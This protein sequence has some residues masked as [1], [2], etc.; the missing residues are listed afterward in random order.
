MNILA[1]NVRTFGKPKIIRYV[2]KNAFSPKPKVDSAI[3]AI[4]IYKK[5]A[6][7]CDLKTYFSLISRAFLHKRKTLRNSLKDSGAVEFLEKA[8][9]D[10]S[11]R[12]ETVSIEEWETL[13]KLFSAFFDHR[14]HHRQ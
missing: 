12:P 9:I 7:S 4:D 8:G 6:A 10:P 5:P 13:T 3:L 11:R 1:L 2:S 14:L